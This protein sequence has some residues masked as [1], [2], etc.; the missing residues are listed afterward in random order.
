MKGDF[1]H[2][3]L[4][5]KVH[6]FLAGE[7][8]FE[9]RNLISSNIKSKALGFLGA[10]FT[11]CPADIVVEFPYPVNIEKVVLNPLVGKHC[12]KS[13]VLSTSPKPFNG[14][15]QRD[16]SYC[17]CGKA[18]VERNGSDAIC[19]GARGF[20]D[21]MFKEKFLLFDQIKI[22]HFVKDRNALKSVRCVKITL[23][24][25]NTVPCLGSIMVVGEPSD[26]R[27]V[28]YGSFAAIC[29][30]I[31]ES[32][33]EV[34][35]YKVKDTP[36]STVGFGNRLDVFSKRTTAREIGKSSSMG[37]VITKDTIDKEEAL[38]KEFEKCLDPI[39]FEVME[40]PVVLPSGNVV[41]RST[42]A[43][44]LLNSNTDPYTGVK[45]SMED[46]T[47]NFSRRNAINRF[48]VENADYVK[49][50]KSIPHRLDTS[51]AR[52]DGYG[53]RSGNKKRE[54]SSSPDR[55]NGRIVRTKLPPVC[56]GGFCDGSLNQPVILRTCN[57][58]FCRKCISSNRSGLCILCQTPYELSNV[59][60]L[61]V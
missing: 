47:S 42:V 3:L 13:I 4:S 27:T 49:K 33:E 37:E 18:F 59:N 2:A 8:G 23:L 22:T 50:I 38:R 36:S 31:V 40:D 5:P 51:A 52:F 53:L 14:I 29:R 61:N 46:V 39:T 10:R 43:K 7:D 11:R 28:E 32:W 35:K 60:R 26:T 48:L 24:N 30:R 54:R 41:D 15:I 57:H 6:C 58:I 34:N 9:V 55:V 12:V 45:L 17:F 19:I 21:F 56:H 1:C 20:R 44:H 25:T 16:P